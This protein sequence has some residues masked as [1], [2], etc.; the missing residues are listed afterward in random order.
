MLNSAHKILSQSAKAVPQKLAFITPSDSITYISLDE[1]SSALATQILNLNINKSPILIIL[2]KG[3]EA[4][5]S[6]FGVLKSGNFYTIID[7]NMPLERINKIIR[8]LCPTL[9]ITSKDLAINL[10]LLT[11][12]IDDLP[13]FKSDQTILNSVKIIDTDLAYTLFTSGSTGEPKGVGISHKSLID[14]TIACVND[15]A[16]DESHTIANQAPFYFDLSVFDIYVNLFAR[17]TAHILPKSIFAFPLHALEYLQKN[18]VT[19]IIWVPSVL[20]YF[21]NS[22]ALNNL[23]SSLKMIIA[24]GEMMPTKQLN[25]WIKAIANAKFYNLYGPTESTLASSYYMVNRE[26]RDDEI[27]PIG[28]A[29]SN[30]ELLVFD[31]DMKLITK[32]NI[33]GELYIRGSGLSHGYY[34]DPVRTAKAFIQNPLQSS[35][36]E[37]IYKTGDIVAY[38]EFG[39]LIYYGRQD[40]QIKLNGFRI[41]L[42]EIETA[43]GAHPDIYR[44]ACIFKDYQIIAFYESANVITNLKEFLKSK[45]QEYMIPRKFIH[46]SK[47]KLNQNGKIDKEALKNE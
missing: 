26:L 28:K 37:P 12:F 9:L 17:A 34:N 35:Y 44:V 39:D 13:G 30:T 7:E 21:A 47:F 38:D 24:C 27:L 4:I 18:R 3:I 33:K 46:K 43:L 8:T 6:F 41:E 23:K 45:L 22:N 36:A 2:P 32:P 14:F 29:F 42:G 1:K 15:L 25:I 40:S 19:T 11:I 10:D 20:V 16:I 31:E 5:I